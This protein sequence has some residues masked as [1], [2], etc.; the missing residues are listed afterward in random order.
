MQISGVPSVIV[1]TG[2]TGFIGS[3]TL[4]ALAGRPGVR[5]RALARVPGAEREGV[6]W[7]RA[8]LT[9]PGSLRGVCE[10]ASALVHLA[11]YIGRDEERCRAV[12][13]A[14]TASLLAEVAR[15]G[16][17]RVVHLSTAAVYGN[18]PHRD[19]E[20]DGIVPDPVS[21]ASRTRLAAEAPALAAGGVVLRPG[22]VL[23]AGDRWV[24]PAL[25]EL[26]S[27][28]PARW[29]GGRAVLSVVGVTELARLIEALATT[30]D[31]F[32]AGIHHASHPTPVTIGDLMSALTAHGIVPPVEE[33]WPWDRCV[34]ALHAHPGVVTE[35][36]FSLLARDYH[37]QSAPIWH[38]TP[39]PP[40]PTPLCFLPNATPW[41]RTHL[42]PL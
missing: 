31:P 8:D 12:N 3:A 16:V 35:R 19:I 10:D 42:A 38:L 41:Y 2:A 34:T 33:D 28:V 11:S 30:S 23:G 25:A 18:R 1:L 20:V 37:Q 4:E 32:P 9:D 5:V 13:V 6:E 26:V 17:K 7:V 21:P 14:G 39:V 36:Q 15:A 22:L 24:V 27:R 40:T 29:D